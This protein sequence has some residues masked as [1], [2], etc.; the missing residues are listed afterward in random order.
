MPDAQQHQHQ[1]Q[2]LEK[3]AYDA[4]FRAQ[5]QASIDDPRP[6]IPDEEARRIFAIK[7]EKL[8]HGKKL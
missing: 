8:R 4:W 1:H 6:S 3:E 2:L 7:R 5:V